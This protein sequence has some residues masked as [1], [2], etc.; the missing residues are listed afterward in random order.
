M[1][2][3][4]SRWLGGWRELFPEQRLAVLASVGIVLSMLLPWY[5]QKGLI[6]RPDGTVL[7]QHRHSQERVLEAKH[8]DAVTAVPFQEAMQ[9]VRTWV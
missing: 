6:T 8:A 1:S 7:Y 3:T 9:N 4:A 2:G 5:Q